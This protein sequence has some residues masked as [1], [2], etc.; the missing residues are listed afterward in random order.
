[1]DRPKKSKR[2]QGFPE[3]IRGL[4][5]ADVQFNGVKAWT[6]QSE[7][8]QLI[9]FEMEPTARVPEHNHEYPQWGVVIQG[10]MKLTINK[11][12]RLY[13]KGDDYLI[14]AK[15]KHYATFLTKSMVIDFFSEK[16]R[17]KAKQA[18]SA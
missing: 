13:K 7:K 4:P 6:L 16:T 5:E 17:Y 18:S 10:K 8:H 12:T 11:R 1:M 15:A 2:A 14:P 3:V 9:F